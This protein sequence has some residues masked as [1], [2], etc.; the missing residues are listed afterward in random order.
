VNRTHEDKL[1]G[2]VETKEDVPVDA[3]TCPQKHEHRALLNQ[4][5]AACGE[6]IPGHG[7]YTPDEYQRYFAPPAAEP[8]PSPYGPDEENARL[9]REYEV[10]R[11]AYEDAA[12]AVEDLRRGRAGIVGRYVGADGNVVVD[13][14]V[15]ARGARAD[16]SIAEAVVRR[17]KRREEAAEILL[18]IQRVDA[19]RGALARRAMYLESYPEPQPSPTLLERAGA[20][21]RGS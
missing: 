2:E 18:E 21:L 1:L 7:M 15:V 5:C 10:A 12:F 20:A 13:H 8:A 9:W 14:G 4:R 19:R 17:E 11:Q 3:A 16:Q 6:T